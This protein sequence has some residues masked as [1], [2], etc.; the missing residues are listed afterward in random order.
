MTTPN[1]VAGRYLTRELFEEWESYF[2]RHGTLGRRCGLFVDAAGS[3]TVLPYLNPPD[4][5]V[6]PAL[7][8]IGV[9]GFPIIA[10]AG[11]IGEGITPLDAAVLPDGRH[12]V[13]ACLA[14]DKA[15]C[16]DL[17]EDPGSAGGQPIRAQVSRHSRVVLEAG[18]RRLE[19][20]DWIQVAVLDRVRTHVSMQTRL[21][22]RFHPQVRDMRAY[23]F[24]NP[25]LELPALV[26]Q[27]V[28][29]RGQAGSASGLRCEL[30][31][32]QSIA[33]EASSLEAFMQVQRCLALMRGI[34][35]ALLPVD[36]R[37]EEYKY[38]P[39]SFCAF[40]ADLR[41]VL[42]P[43]DIRPLFPDLLK[44]DSASNG[45][46]Q[47]LPEGLKEEETGWTWS[48]ARG[49]FAANAL[50]IYLPKAKPGTL[51]VIQYSQPER[52]GPFH[53]AQPGRQ[54]G[55]TG[56]QGA[57]VLMTEIGYPVRKIF[58]TV[59]AQQDRHRLRQYLGDGYALYYC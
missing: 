21:D 32:L 28:I 12:K 48:P 57:V 7:R 39:D 20:R 23:A 36:H 2:E 3:K 1:P 55:D 25:L 45:T 11:S 14:W 17:F 59:A 27:E 15:P 47:K 4:V 51:P 42:S 8:A 24:S 34:E 54:I 50:A 49:Q 10:S 33:E 44:I 46:Y 35:P 5:V 53:V 30:S 19:H 29:E 43:H 52:T 6:L 58:V 40:L 16:G 26:L 18:E 9:N 31:I 38:T 22:G 37:L 56:G 13:Y 41:D